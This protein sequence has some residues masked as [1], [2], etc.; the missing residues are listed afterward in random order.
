MSEPLAES[1]AEQQ[2]RRRAFVW[3]STGVGTWFGA[4]GMQ[5]VLF[6]WIV[7]GEL[8]A[9]SEWVGIAQTSTMLP[10]LFFLLAGGVV[11]D[12]V[13]P[14]R[15]LIVLHLTAAL[16]AF[17]LAASS[18]MGALA[19]PGI[20]AYGLTIGTIQAFVMPARD[21][22]LSRVAG[23]DMMRA[24][25]AMTAAQFSAQALGTLLA[26]AARWTGSAT[27][28][29][30]Q[31]LV[32][33]SGS[34]FTRGIPP[35]E[36]RPAA[37][38]RRAG[39]HDLVDGLAQVVRTPNLRIP[40]SMVVS[41]GILFIGPFVVVFPLLVRDYYHGGVA[42]LSLILM[43]FPVGTIVGSFVLRYRGIA[44]KGRAALLALCAGALTQ[45]AIGLGVPFWGMV[46]LT[47]LWGLAGSVFINCS[48]TLYQ[49]AAPVEQRGRVLAVYQLGFIGG[50]PIGSTVSGFLSGA[51]GLHWT[52]IAAAAA[53]GVMAVTLAL[54]SQARTM[55]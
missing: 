47:F 12:R 18:A 41:V 28:L 53:M 5:Q 25:T 42:S 55:R 23:P 54:F 15:M 22:L 9:S 20:I 21:T 1:L 40:V 27:M 2:Q 49:E 16:P 13:D 44:R 43:L 35:V 10:A 51:V 29:A 8:K 31:G 32:V 30:V 50:A 7:V 19:L 14:R 33:A 36:P 4:W 38:I 37:S 39:L 48:R 3:Y 52:L 34:F 11:A 46:I 17:A 24:V 26:G 45:A 6:S